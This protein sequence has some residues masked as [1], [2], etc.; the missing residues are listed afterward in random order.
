MLE[1]KQKHNIKCPKCK[2]TDT[3]PALLGFTV[4]THYH[5][6]CGFVVDIFKGRTPKITI[7]GVE[8]KPITKISFNIKN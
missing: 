6:E 1:S 5:C 4:F 8:I 7:D 2:K 3:I